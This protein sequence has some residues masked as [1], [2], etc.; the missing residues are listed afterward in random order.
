MSTGVMELTSA[1]SYSETERGVVATRVFVYDP[2]D[3]NGGNAEV[4]M[5]G[6]DFGPIPLNISSGAVDF[7]LYAD[8]L[9]CRSRTWRSLGGH[10]DKGEWVCEYSNEPTDR[11]VFR[12]SGDTSP[13][14]VSDLP[15]NIQYSGEFASINPVQGQQTSTWT[16]LSDSTSVLQAIHFRVN[17]S[18]VRFTRYVDNSNYAS[19]AGEVRKLSGKVNTNDSPFGSAIGGG[20]RCWLFVGATAEIFRNQDDEKFWRVDL[21][22]VYRDPDGLSYDG[23]DKILR[24]DGVWD[25]PIKSGGGT[26]YEGASFDTL[27]Q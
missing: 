12:T 6:D 26:L 25:V 21:E 22:F 27:F 9:I 20:P 10:P 4:P 14:D 1:F 8:N 23:W 17:S 15:T 18:T 13:T 7:H 24:L 5:V 19:F 11:S 2:D 3:I 16:W